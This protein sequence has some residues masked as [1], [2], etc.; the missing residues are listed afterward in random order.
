[1]ISGDGINCV[2]T[3]FCAAG[4]KPEILLANNKYTAHH[5]PEVVMIGMTRKMKKKYLGE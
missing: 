4:I 3:K 5:F 2:L 1:M